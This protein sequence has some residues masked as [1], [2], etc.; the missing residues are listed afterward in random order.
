MLKKTLI[1]LALVSTTVSGSAMAWTAGGNGGT[2]ELGGTLTPS[3]PVTSPWEVLVG[4]AVN[5]LQ[6]S[7]KPGDTS[8]LIPVTNPITVLGIRTQTNQPFIGKVGLSPQ[9]SY[10]GAYGIEATTNSSALLTLSVLD[11]QNGSVIGELRAKMLAGAITSSKPTS[12]GGAGDQHPVFAKTAGQ[13]FYGGLS[14]NQAVVDNNIKEKLDAINPEFSAHYDSQNAPF[15]QTAAPEDYSATDSTFSGYYGAGISAADAGSI[16]LL[17]NSPAGN[18]PITWKAS[19]P[20]T[21]S[22]Q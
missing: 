16:T 13:S 20:I 2:F 3:G 6:T 9:I 18:S 4:S 12:G 1:A 22:Y 11:A 21:V 19:L 15:S 17:L 8:V 7:I 5:N 10:N 14:T